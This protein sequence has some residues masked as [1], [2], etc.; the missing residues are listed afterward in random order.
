[1]QYLRLAEILEDV[2]EQETID[3]ERFRFNGGENHIKLILLNSVRPASWVTIEANLKN[4]DYVMELLMATDALRRAGFDHINLVAPYIPGGRQD[5]VMVPGEPLTI[6]VIAD[7]INAQNYEVVYTLDPHSSV[8]PALINNC[9]EISNFRIISR[10]IFQTFNG[11]DT[12]LVSPDAGAEKKTLWLAR[13]SNI[14]VVNASKIRDVR[15]GQINGTKV[16]CDP[17][18]I[19]GKTCVIVDDICDGGRTFLELAKVLKQK[20]AE[21]I[22]LFVSHAILPLGINHL[23]AAGIDRVFTA[24][25]FRLEHDTKFWPNLQIY[26]LRKEDLK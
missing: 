17:K 2:T 20:G 14:D 10:F 6:K 9:V 19:E 12:L 24:N 5:R 3:F 15:T 23:V 22:L 4:A 1:M 16:H 7:L 18:K 26:N 13:Y 25:C 21:K 8:T 11:P